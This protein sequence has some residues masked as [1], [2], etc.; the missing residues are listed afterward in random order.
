MRVD[1]QELRLLA[2]DADDATAEFTA[3]MPTVL[4]TTAERLQALTR[5]DDPQ[6]KKHAERALYHLYRLVRDAA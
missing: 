4:R 1:R 2:T 6:Q 5:G 3:N